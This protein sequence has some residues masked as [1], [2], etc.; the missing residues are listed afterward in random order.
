MAYRRTER[1][2][3]RFNAR[4]EAIVEAARALA[5]EGGMEAVQINTVAA[6][7]SIAASTSVSISVTIAG[8]TEP[9]SVS[10]PEATTAG[11]PLTGAASR[12]VPP[13]PRAPRSGR[14][15]RRAPARP[16]RSP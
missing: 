7:A 16:C 11:L 14:S 4:R 1:V 6:R 8:G 2:I 13:C 15:R 9:S 12:S 10:R 5:A 3:Q